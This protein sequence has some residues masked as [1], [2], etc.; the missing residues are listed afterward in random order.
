MAWKAN[1]F[2]VVHGGAP[3]DYIQDYKMGVDAT[4][5][6]LKYILEA[7]QQSNQQQQNNTANLS[8]TLAEGNRSQL[9][10]ATLALDRAKQAHYERSDTARLNLDQARENRLNEQATAEA[11]LNPYKIALTKSQIANFKFDQDNKIL[12]LNNQTEDSLN[13]GNFIKDMHGLSNED[14][15]NGKQDEIVQ[16]YSPLFH[17]Q[18]TFKRMQDVLHERVDT[19]MV[20][21][22][23]KEMGLWNP[24]ELATFK[25]DQLPK[26]KGGEGL[27]FQESYAH[28]NGMY[29]E[30]TNKANVKADDEDTGMNSNRI[31]AQAK[32]G[33]NS[34][35][36]DPF[37]TPEDKAAVGYADDLARAWRTL[38]KQDPSKD[39]YYNSNPA[40]ALKDA[41][42]T[43]T[44]APGA[45]AQETT[46]K[47]SFMDSLLGKPST[48]A[49]TPKATPQLNPSGNTVPSTDSNTQPITTQGNP[50]GMLTP[51]QHDVLGG[52]QDWRAEQLAALQQ[53]QQPDNAEA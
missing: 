38:H 13:L 23:T 46:E 17:N 43:N 37:S 41:G 20:A 1:D 11:A 19:G 31:S 27:S 40:Q 47:H 50:L 10:Q 32:Y 18:E 14:L 53:S 45:K 15:V 8:A 36:L 16:R 49:A 30:R 7:N 3:R 9:A 2:Q 48:P 52:I 26:D 44:P 34:K 35:S 12:T 22:S 42:Y 6:P 29:Q 33:I 21:A 5:E 28:A 51:E 24:R 4:L 39:D 25:N